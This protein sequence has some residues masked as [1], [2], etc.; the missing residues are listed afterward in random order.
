MDH[1][2]VYKEQASPVA[3]D[4]F[5][6]VTTALICQNTLLRKGIGHILSGTRFVLSEDVCEDANSLPAFSTAPDLFLICE[7]RRSD[8]YAEAVRR[9]KARYPSARVVIFADQMEPRAIIQVCQAGVDGLCSTTMNHD[10]LIKALGLVMLGETFLSA[11]LSLPLLDQMASGSHAAVAPAPVNDLSSSSRLSAREAQ[12][13]RCLMQG[14]SNKLIARDLGV[15]EATVKV[16]I[17]TILRKVKVANRTQAAMW[18]QQNL[19]ASA[20]P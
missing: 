18:A 11:G 15:A 12:I 2:I 5:H 20:Q 10:A 14:S 8:E 9:L 16:H 13:L 17:K 1:N 6:P 3:H 4:L 19:A 7:N